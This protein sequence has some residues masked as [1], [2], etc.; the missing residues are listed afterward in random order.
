MERTLDDFAEVAFFGHVRCPR[1]C[2]KRGG[3]FVG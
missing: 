2:L 1:L 3:I